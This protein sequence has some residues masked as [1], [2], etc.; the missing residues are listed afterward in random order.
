MTPASTLCPR[1]PSSTF[2]LQSRRRRCRRRCRH[3]QRQRRYRRRLA[4]LVVHFLT[5]EATRSRMNRESPSYKQG[6]K[7]MLVNLS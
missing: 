1:V 4:L 7:N 6:Y 2:V 5:R 3:T